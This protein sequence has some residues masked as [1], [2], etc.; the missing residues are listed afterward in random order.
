MLSEKTLERMRTWGIEE[1]ERA[2]QV[3]YEKGRA[4]ER[5]DVAAREG[6]EADP[7]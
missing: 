1:I 7:E 3:A 5:A 6:I 2:I 4:D